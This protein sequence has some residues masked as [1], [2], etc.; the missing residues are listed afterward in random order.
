MFRAGGVRWAARA[1]AM[2][3]SLVDVTGGGWQKARMLIER[4]S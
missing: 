3:S 4:V 2:I 1:G